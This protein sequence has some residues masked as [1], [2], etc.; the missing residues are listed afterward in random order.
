MSLLRTMPVEDVLNRGRQGGLIRRLSGVDLVGIG[1]GIIIGTGVF[2]LA[3]IE[4][5]DHAGPAVVLSF[6]IGGV[7]A[8]LAAV[9]YAE[10]TSAVPTAGSAYTYAYAT[11]GEVFAWIIGWDLLLEFALGA[12]VVSRSWS[13]YVSNL[14]GLPPEYFGEDATVNVG[15]M[16]IIAVLTVVAVAG[17][18][19]SAW[20]TNALVVVKVSV[21]VLVV[22]AGLF[23][24]RG[25]NLVPFV[26]PAQP[27]E[28][29]ASLLEQ[30]LVQALLGMD[31]SVYGFGGVLT[32]A[33]IVFFAYTGF[34]ALA[35][36][37]EET[38]RPRRDLPVGLL[39]SLAICTLL[40]VAV[41]LV[42]SAMVP[43]Q[44][45]DEGAPL[46][47]AFQ[48]V[49]VPW[50]AGLISLG[51][52]TGLTSVMMVE[53]VTIGRIGFA[54]SRDGLLPRKLSQVH[55]RWGTPHRMTIGGAVVIMLLA[56]F[57]PISELADMVS[58][59]ALSG[60]V[61]VTLAVPVLRRRRPDLERPFRVPFSPWLP[62]LAAVACL[63][64]MSNLDVITWLRFGAWLVLGMA[65][66]LLY[67]RRHSGLAAAARE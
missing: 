10:L 59:G 56:G 46:A 12:A 66:Y 61:I 55:P 32:A 34:E 17:I 31:Q 52:V 30:P 37:G 3:G 60:F 57:V 33:A 15:A 7:V 42:L 20:V 8:A 28:G 4:A 11:I 64:L 26:P 63:Y 62:I 49:G 21:C 58:I 39:G 45:I 35:N 65:I 67:G 38:K 23:F 51:A 54:M 2:T 27:A 53:L 48:S 40:Y 14:L 24:F 44:Q 41:A 47:A 36:L 29:G 6:V 1:I 25:A 16:L 9:C 13:G 18:R 5:K 50:V 19:E 22:V 43:Y